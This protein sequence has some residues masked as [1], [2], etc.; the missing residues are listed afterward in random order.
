MVIKMKVAGLVSTQQQADEI[1]SIIKVFMVSVRARYLGNIAHRKQIVH[2]MINNN[3][4]NN[5]E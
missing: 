4:I 3:K 2:E 5:G 1:N